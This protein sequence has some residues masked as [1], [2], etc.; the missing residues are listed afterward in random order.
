MNPH[1]S[2]PFRYMD[3][4]RIFQFIVLVFCPATL[5]FGFSLT[6]FV[7]TVMSSAAEPGIEPSRQWWLATSCW[8]SKELDIQKSVESKYRTKR[9][10]SHQLEI[11]LQMKVAKKGSWRFK[12]ACFKLAIVTVSFYTVNSLNSCCTATFS[13]SKSLSTVNGRCL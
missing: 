8:T 4:F 13:F 1:S 5:L 7:C 10:V 11:Q 2:L 6:A 3:R 12:A 9:S